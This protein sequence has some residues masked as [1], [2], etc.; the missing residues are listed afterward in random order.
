LV[1]DDRS[2]SRAAQA[3]NFFGGGSMWK[4]WVGFDLRHVGRKARPTL[5]NTDPF[6]VRDPHQK[7]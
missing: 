3:G 1:G 6:D 5:A 7:I 2:A 4:S